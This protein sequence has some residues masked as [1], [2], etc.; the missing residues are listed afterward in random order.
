M[1]KGLKNTA[2]STIIYGLG[3][4]STKLV[5]I[6]LLPLFTDTDILS[7]EEVGVLGVVDVTIQILVAILGLSLY[8][9]LFRWYWDK[10]F[11]T[12]RKS[13]FFT[14]LVALTALCLG[15]VV[16]GYFTSLQMS[17]LL[18]N[19]E[20]YSKVVFLMLIA[21]SLQILT[22]VPMSLMR[23]QEKPTMYTI[24]NILRLVVSLVFTIV[25]LTK[26]G[27]GLEG[28]Y[29]AQILGNLFFFAITSKYIVNSC[30]AVFNRSI[31]K[32]MLAYSIPLSIASVSGVILATLDRYVL[33]YRATLM[34]VA[35]YTIAFRITNTIRVFIVHSVQLAIA[36]T[37]FKLMNHPDNRLIYARIMTYFS[38]L[39]IYASLALSVFGLEVIDLFVSDEVYRSAYKLIPFLSIPILLGTSKDIA[40]NGLNI[41][42]KTKIV[43]LIVPIIAV[44]HLGL[45]FIII[46]ILG[47]YGAAIAS[48]VSQGI[49]LASVLYLAQ[50]YYPVPYE[51]KRTLISFFIAILLYALSTQINEFSLLLRLLLKSSIVLSYPLLVWIFIKLEADEKQWLREGLSRFKH[52]F[53]RQ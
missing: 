5:G 37:I 47:V 21:S 49:F 43:S 23:L 28:I 1:L 41:A 10:N 34:D 13:I 52:L 18:F 27:R 32:E 31:L 7:I 26:L 4:I 38:I 22:Q 53:V 25:F 2:K 14:I 39:V 46:P 45:N 16:F 9:A 50:K 30:N 40:I 20:V 44:F 24:S 29:E 15:L 36:P 48:T 19:D 12:E 11:V 3:N 42:K 8:Q 35:I 51:I 33:N 17:V 6:V